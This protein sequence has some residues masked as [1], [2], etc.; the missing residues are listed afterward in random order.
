MVVLLSV[1]CVYGDVNPGLFEKPKLPKV[2]PSKRET[3]NLNPNPLQSNY[4]LYSL[5]F[6]D[7]RASAADSELNKGLTQTVVSARN[8]VLE[9]IIC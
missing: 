6:W 3:A 2:Q 8:H 4:P 9:V 1:Q 5:V 7:I